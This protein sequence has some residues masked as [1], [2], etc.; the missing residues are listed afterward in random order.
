[1]G[2][3]PNDKFTIYQ[4]QEGVLFSTGQDFREVSREDLFG[5]PR[6]LKISGLVKQIAVG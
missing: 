5:I 6:E 4:S 2:I 1:M 3:Y